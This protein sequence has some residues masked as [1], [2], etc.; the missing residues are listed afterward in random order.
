MDSSCWQ[1]C[2]LVL[3]GPPIPRELPPLDPIIL[4][5][6]F[7][8]RVKETH[9]DRW[10]GD[11][12][13]LRRVTQAYQYLQNLAPICSQPVQP[14]HARTSPHVPKRK[15]ALGQFLFHLGYVE[16]INVVDALRWQQG[17]RKPLGVLG[18]N[19]GCLQEGDVGRILRCRRKGERFGDCAR[20]MGLLST[21][22][23]GGLLRRQVEMQRPIG[24]YFVGQG[25]LSKE[26]L[27]EVLQRLQEHNQAIAALNLSRAA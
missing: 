27:E 16:W 5:S 3:F 10:G 24:Q 1:S 14:V 6:C 7:R 20:R 19:L 9:P 18:M 25:I 15:L 8:R 13:A 23:V 4:K 2:W 11:G 26:G 17:Q 21:A 22:E 12:Q